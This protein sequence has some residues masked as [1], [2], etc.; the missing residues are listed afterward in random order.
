[1]F[2]FVT[3]FGYTV[4]AKLVSSKHSIQ[5]QLKIFS[6]SVKDMASL[7]L[8]KYITW[9]FTAKTLWVKSKDKINTKLQKAL[10]QRKDLIVLAFVAIN[11]V[12]DMHKWFYCERC[13]GAEEK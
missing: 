4:E 7:S 13:S 11:H 12:C 5:V 8:T 3:I 1:M 6:R 2:N 10:F 9:T